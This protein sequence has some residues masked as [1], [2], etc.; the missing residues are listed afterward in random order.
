MAVGRLG[1]CLCGKLLRKCTFWNEKN[2]RALEQCV[3][4]LVQTDFS[5]RTKTTKNV[6]TKHIFLAQNIWKMRVAKDPPH[7]TLWDLT[8]LLQ[9]P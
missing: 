8:A 7:T 6:A 5:I 3:L 9:T 1:S 4:F 2:L